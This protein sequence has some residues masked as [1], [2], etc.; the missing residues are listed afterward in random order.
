MPRSAPVLLLVL[1]SAACAASPGGPAPVMSGDPLEET[2]RAV[3]D[4]NLALDDCCIK[5]I[6][7]GYEALVHPWVRTRIRGMAQT[8]EEPRFAANRLLQGR[9][10]EAGGH[11]MRFVINTTMGLGGMFDMEQIGGPPRR[12]T[13]IGATLHGWGVGGGPYLML[14]V[15]GPSTLRDSTIWTVDG[16]LNPINWLVPFWAPM[17]KA[18]VEGLDLRTENLEALEALRAESLDVYARL[19][20]VW[21]QQRAADLGISAAEGEGLDILEDPDADPPSPR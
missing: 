10:V 14:P 21:R 18:T 11:V 9:P 7:Q 2:N 3:L 1:L 5:P 15:L 13:D 8:W 19:R 4:V 16:F 20:S 6:A 12:P 17:A